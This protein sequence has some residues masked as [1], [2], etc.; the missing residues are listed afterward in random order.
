[1]VTN[2]DN[3]IVV[4][5]CNGECVSV[6][7]PDGNKIQS[8]GSKG[9]GNGQFYSPRG[10]AQDNEGNIYVVDEGNNR[11]QKFSLS[12][13][14]TSTVGKRGTDTLQFDIPLGITFNTVTGKLYVCDRNNHRIQVLNTD[15]TLHSIFGTQGIGNGQFEHPIGSACDSTG[16]V[17]I[18]DNYNH[19]IQVFTPG[20]K[21]L[22][23]FG[24]WGSGPGQLNKP[25]D[26][27]IGDNKLYVCDSG[28][29]RICVFTIGGKFLTSFGSQG[30]KQSKFREPCG[31]H[32]TE[33]GYL[34]VS[35]F[36]NNRIQVF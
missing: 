19:R 6:L 34:L 11:I 20:G 32:I 23:K 15:L 22:R 12:G 5:E 10:I 4:A 16:N 28:N 31:I 2:A 27:T 24:S 13:K 7:T 35:D 18:A 3:Q 33:D 29:K 30:Q 1:M 26:V 9:S 17:Y 8:I 21:F 14:F 36:Q 25:L